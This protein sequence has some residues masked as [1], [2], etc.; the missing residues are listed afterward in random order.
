MNEVEKFIARFHSSE[1]I[2]EVFTTG[3]CYWFAEILRRRFPKASGIIV[4][5]EIEGH[6]GTELGG[7]VFDITGDV[8][9]KYKWTEFYKV[10]KARRERIIRDCIMF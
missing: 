1:D 7:R 8:T 9:D 5:D 3:C 4:Y 6:F 10:D 2:T